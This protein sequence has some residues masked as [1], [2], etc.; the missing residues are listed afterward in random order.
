MRVLLD[1]CTVIELRNPRGDQA[2]KAAIALIPDDNLYLSTL[3]IG[4]IARRI[5]LLP[6]NRAKASAK[7]LVRHSGDTV[8]SSCV[9][10]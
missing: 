5:A 4:E 8:R 10:S 7:Y 6:D 9:D 1:L 3:T 2:V